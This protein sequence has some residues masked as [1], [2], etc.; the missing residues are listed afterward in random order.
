MMTPRLTKPQAEAYT[1][2]R[3]LLLSK[4]HDLH[5]FGRTERAKKRLA[6]VTEALKAFKRNKED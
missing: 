2:E 5:A 3:K 1:R 4:K 6:Y